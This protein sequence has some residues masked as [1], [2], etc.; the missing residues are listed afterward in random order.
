[1]SLE[2]IAPDKQQIV[3]SRSFSRKLTDYKE[4]SEALAEYCTRAAEKLRH[5]RIYQLKFPKKSSSH[6]A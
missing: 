1:M 6:H 3:C 2:E 4:L 5:Q